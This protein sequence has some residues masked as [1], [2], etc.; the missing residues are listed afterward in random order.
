M[1]KPNQ[2]NHRAKLIQ[3]RGFTGF[4][5]TGELN[6][7]AKYLFGARLK[8]KEQVPPDEDAFP[9]EHEY[10]DTDSFDDPN[11]ALYGEQYDAGFCPDLTHKMW[12]R[13]C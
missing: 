7:H 9:D 10:D 13:S 3:D 11:S 1:N 6:E 12:N 4:P 8:L 5:E 2:L